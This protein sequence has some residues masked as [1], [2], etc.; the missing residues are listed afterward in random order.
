[1]AETT[2]TLLAG[3]LLTHVGNPP[4]LTES[5][6]VEKAIATEEL[7]R[8]T[9]LTTMLT[10]TL[11]Q[12]ADLQPT[13]LALMHGASFTGDGAAQLCGLAAGYTELAAR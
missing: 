4:P 9:G 12:L 6:V 5:D 1:M 7:F 13:T 11:H 2:S 3:D 10:P 8:A